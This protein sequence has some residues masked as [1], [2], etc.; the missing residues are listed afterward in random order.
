M[1]AR[2]GQR[3]EAFTSAVAEKKLK[4]GSASRDGLVRG[5]GLAAMIVGVVGAFVAYQL[6]LG[7]EDSRDTG[8][9]QI[10]AVAFLALSVLGVGFYLAG[11]L[12][13]LMRLWLLRQVV[14]SQERHDELVAAL[15]EQQ[16]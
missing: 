9:A 11:S 14:E 5:V 15:R 2:P 1:S 16:R 12:S 13:A 8:S 4:T 10:L 6:S 3:S 7:Y